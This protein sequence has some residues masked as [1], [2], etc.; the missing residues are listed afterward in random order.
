MCRYE[1]AHSH[2]LTKQATAGGVGTPWGRQTQMQGCQTRFREVIQK[3]EIWFP[4]TFVADLNFDELRWRCQRSAR[5]DGG[6]S[7]QK[8]IGNP[9]AYRED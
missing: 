1:A 3:F 4:A 7:G 9:R 2:S 6:V 5:I 8:K